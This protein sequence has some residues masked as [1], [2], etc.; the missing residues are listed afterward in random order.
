VYQFTNGYYQRI[1]LDVEVFKNTTIIQGLMIDDDN[2]KLYAYRPIQT[3]G[4][5]SIERYR[6]EFLV[7]DL[8]TGIWTRYSLPFGNDLIPSTNVRT[9]FTSD[10]TERI[11]FAT[12]SSIYYVDNQNVKY[13]KYI[14][15]AGVT[16]YI[17]PQFKMITKSFTFDDMFTWKRLR[18]IVW[19]V[20]NSTGFNYPVRILFNVQGEATGSYNTYAFTYNDLDGLMGMNLN[21]YRFKAILLNV[22]FNNGVSSVTSQP[23]DYL[24]DDYEMF[25][26]STTKQPARAPLIRQMVLDIQPGES[27][28]LETASTS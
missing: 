23:A 9:S 20:A 8:N 3:S 7:L 12:G 14:D 16:N 15:V 5:F 13:D 4:T 1:S 21:K 11:V 26:N 22:L 10:T 18:R 6:T 2:N 25:G 28:T 17:L 24:W 27:S 19:D